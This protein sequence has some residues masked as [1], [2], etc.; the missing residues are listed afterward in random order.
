MPRR[1]G[2]INPAV[3]RREASVLR[4]WTQGA[5]FRACGPTSLARERVPLHPSACRRSASLMGDEGHWQAS[6]DPMPR[7]NDDVC[8]EIVARV[9]RSETRE[10]RVGTATPDFASLNPGYASSHA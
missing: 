7:E 10:R 2:A 6:E 9:E 3:E 4:H 8:A 5:T 1:T